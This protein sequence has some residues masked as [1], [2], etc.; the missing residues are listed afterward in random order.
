MQNNNRMWLGLGDWDIYIYIYI[1]IFIHSFIH[2]IDGALPAVGPEK[3]LHPYL[4]TFASQYLPLSI[5]LLEAVNAPKCRH[6][7]QF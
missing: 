2:A 1:Y 4:A 5:Q 3:G 7:G 6:I